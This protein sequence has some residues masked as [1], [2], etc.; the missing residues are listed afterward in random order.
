MSNIFASLRKDF[1]KRTFKRYHSD[2]YMRVGESWRKPRGLDNRV[3]KKYSGTPL[4][5]NK[6]FRLPAI[7]RDRVEVVN[8]TNNNTNNNL[9]SNTN[10]NLNSN[11]N[12]NNTLSLRECVIRNVD[13]L[14]ALSPLNLQ[15]CATIAK[16]TGSRKRIEIVNEAK[17][18]NILLTNGEARLALEVPE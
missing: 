3:R 2:R 8:N 7:L 5:P 11:T 1:K 13:E 12:N 10:N 16:A 6:R 18:L 14:R 9:N 15:Y 4:M 17:K